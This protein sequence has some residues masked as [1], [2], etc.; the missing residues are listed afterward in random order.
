[1]ILVC[2][3]RWWLIS[4]KHSPC[5]PAYVSSESCVLSFPKAI[6]V[7]R[8]EACGDGKEHVPEGEARELRVPTATWE[9]TLVQSW[10]QA[11]TNTSSMGINSEA[12]WVAEYLDPCSILWDDSGH[13]KGHNL[14]PSFCAGMFICYL[15]FARLR[16]PLLGPGFLDNKD[17]IP[18]LSVFLL[19]LAQHISLNKYMNEWIR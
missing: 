13:N 8:G 9:Q 5:V 4:G 19:L 17:H 11:S 18:L 14:L 1:M 6:E 15:S 12:S 2:A 3:Y 16:I 10:T 7:L